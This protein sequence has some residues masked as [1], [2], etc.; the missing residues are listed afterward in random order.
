[1][2]LTVFTKDEKLEQ[3]LFDRNFNW[4]GI[5]IA[6]TTK[7]NEE[8]IKSLEESK[9][10]YGIFSFDGT[11]ACVTGLGLIFFP[12]PVQNSES[13]GARYLAYRIKKGGGYLVQHL[14]E[15]MPPTTKHSHEELIE[16]FYN[17]LGGCYIEINGLLI[18]LK[19]SGYTAYPGDSHMLT[20]HEPAINL[21]V[22]K[23]PWRGLSTADHHYS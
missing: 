1:M 2:E 16:E 21:L 5:E 20:T 8:L 13:S 10:P 19:Q 4:D 18:P 6:A 12:Y 3:R 9:I 23:G 7:P 17:L 11:N 22:M 15:G 14:D